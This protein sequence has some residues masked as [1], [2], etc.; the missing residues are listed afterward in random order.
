MPHF[1]LSRRFLLALLLVA[2]LLIAAC[3]AET[4]DP[5]PTRTPRPTFTPEPEVVQTP[6]DPAAA[7]T[8][9]AARPAPAEPAQ[10]IDVQPAEP[11]EPVQEQ[12]VEQEPA[13]EQPAQEQP[14][15][16]PEPPTPEPAAEAV[17]STNMNVRGGPGTNYSIVGAAN[18]G[19]RFAITGKNDA[20]NWWQIDFRGQQGWVFGDLI[21]TENTGSVAVA[22]NIP[23]PPPTPVPVA[24]PPPPPAEAQPAEPAPPPA[25]QAPPANDNFPFALAETAQC[26]PNEGN[27]Y[28]EG[29]VRDANNNLLNAVCVHIAFYGPRGTKC[30]GCDGVGD[31]R[32]GFSPFGGPAPSGTFVEIFIVP[33]EGEMP[34][35]GQTEQ[36]GFGDLT[37]Q[38]PKWSRTINSSEQCT[39]ITF[40]KK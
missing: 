22:Q 3:G 21:S 2:S 16:T 10:P 23:A 29:F 27:T 37:P 5:L 20:G 33:C 31:G 19:E 14:T 17:I 36:S 34:K 15:N 11:A 8:A 25:E 13:G 4:A 26:A 6:V 12:P 32:W 9:Q 1:S 38:S 28:F 35:G 30:S 18:S 24:Q 7:A 40:Y 39:G